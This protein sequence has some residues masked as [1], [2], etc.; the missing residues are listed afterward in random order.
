M[1]E[2]EYVGDHKPIEEQHREIMNEVANL[3]DKVFA[4]HG[5]T[6]LVF[7]FHRTDDQSRMNYIS[8]ARR[9]DML[10]A[11]KEFI[12]RNEGRAHDSKER[13]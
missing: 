12:A 8:N 7:D 4:G 5:W 13:H 6:L 11:M 1:A 10:V 3:L 2:N 9:E